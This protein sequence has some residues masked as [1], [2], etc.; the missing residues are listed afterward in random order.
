MSQAGQPS[1][2]DGGGGGGGGGGTPHWG[3]KLRRT[4]SGLSLQA[5]HDGTGRTSLHIAAEEGDARA[6]AMLLR[7]D[8]AAHLVGAVD[9]VRMHLENQAP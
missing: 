5:A 1:P 9:R 7:T 2:A 3:R 6:V 8:A 4:V